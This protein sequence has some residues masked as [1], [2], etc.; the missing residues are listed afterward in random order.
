[1]RTAFSDL[2]SFKSRIIRHFNPGVANAMQ[3]NPSC[4]NLALLSKKIAQHAKEP[5]RRRTA[6]VAP[7]CGDSYDFKCS[8]LG[9]KRV[10]LVRNDNDLYLIQKRTIC[11]QRLAS[12]FK[13]NLI[14]LGLLFEAT[15]LALNVSPVLL[16]PPNG[17]YATNI[18]ALELVDYSRIDPYD[19][20][21]GLRRL[22]VSVFYPT[23]PA[24]KCRHPE[25]YPYAPSRTAAALGKL[26]EGYGWPKATPY[27]ERVRLGVCPGDRGGR[28]FGG[29]KNPHMKEDFPVVLFSHGL[30][31]T[32]L[33]SSAQAQAVASQGFVVITIDHPYDA[34]A[35]EFPDGSL[36]LGRQN[37]TN[38]ELDEDVRVRSQDASFVIDSF[39]SKKS[40]LRIHCFNDVKVAM[41]GHSLGGA[42]SVRTAYDDPQILGALDLDGSP[43]GFN[44]STSS[45]GNVT[46]QLPTNM[47]TPFL[48]FTE[49]PF[50]DA[51]GMPTLYASFSG[52]K[53]HLALKNSRH[54][55]FMDLPLLVDTFGLRGSLPEEFEEFS[56]T[57]SGLR[58]RDVV[59]AYVGAFMGFVLKGSDDGLLEGE[60]ARFPE[61][62][63]VAID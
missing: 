59:A 3:L 30:G 27:L 56:G 21:G 29:W 47:T 15:T 25:L 62:E 50:I 53:R 16:P 44:T 18:Q 45:D 10:Q 38:A 11:C 63:F 9:Y 43:Y 41:F 6:L 28:K 61:V 32:R 24:E 5:K 39:K 51:A 49:P 36:V 48:L 35:T 58:A 7:G 23:M 14:L 12:P 40:P 19:P 52:W 22:M 60:S 54:L 26:L 31:T 13:M 4:R 17:K 42:T 8:A 37:W 46:F 33:G 1:M 57:I 34:V 2:C 55:T 20:N